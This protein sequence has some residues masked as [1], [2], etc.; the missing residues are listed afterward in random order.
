MNKIELTRTMAKVKCVYCTES[1]EFP[2]DV[3]TS[4]A[5]KDIKV[6]QE[7]HGWRFDGIRKFEYD[8][9]CPSCDKSKVLRTFGMIFKRWF[10]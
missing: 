1:F 9:A 7:P 2:I 6:S 5:A 8:G 10:K 3:E 4:L